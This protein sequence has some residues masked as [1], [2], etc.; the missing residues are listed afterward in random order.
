MVSGPKRLMQIG[1]VFA[2]LTM[3]AITF[4]WRIRDCMIFWKN[5]HDEPLE[6]GLSR[7]VGSFSSGLGRLWSV[8]NYKKLLRAKDTLDESHKK[9]WLYI[10]VFPNLVLVYT[11]ILLFFI[12]NTLSKTENYPAWGQL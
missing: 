10:G 6:D 7:S 5:Y 4:L 12:R 8:K 3:K 2:M 9:C 1:N 11:Q